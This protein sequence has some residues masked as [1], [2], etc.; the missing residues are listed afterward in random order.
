MRLSV[1]NLYVNLGAK[2]Q[3]TVISVNFLLFL[4]RI[5][6]RLRIGNILVAKCLEKT[7]DWERPRC[8]KSFPHAQAH[9]SLWAGN[10]LIAHEPVKIVCSTSK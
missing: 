4:G 8:Q 3:N 5:L 9:T 1:N 7:P 2:T 10:V 6:K